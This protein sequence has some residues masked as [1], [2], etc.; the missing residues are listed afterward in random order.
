MFKGLQPAVADET[1]ISFVK[2]RDSLGRLLKRKDSPRESSG[3]G[4]RSGNTSPVAKFD[5]LVGIYFKPKLTMA[6]LKP[7]RLSKKCSLLLERLHSM[8][9]TQ[10]TNFPLVHVNP[11]PIDTVNSKEELQK[12]LRTRLP[13]EA[14]E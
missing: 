9:R 2:E 7:M 3:T 8:N 1:F 10:K 12:M 11:E 5:D 14:A 6:A 13:R 4:I